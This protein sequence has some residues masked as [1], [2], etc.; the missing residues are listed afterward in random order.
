MAQNPERVM[1]L[2]ELVREREGITIS[3]NALAQSMHWQDVAEVDKAMAVAL[4]IGR[5][6]VNPMQAFVNVYGEVEAKRM[7]REE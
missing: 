1:R 3:A 6:H 7:F 2:R 5:D 4:L